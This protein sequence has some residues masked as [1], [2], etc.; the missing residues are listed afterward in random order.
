LA[1]VR[2]RPLCVQH[3]S[4]TPLFPASGPA[5]RSS[6]AFHPKS[7]FLTPPSRPWPG[8]DRDVT[9]LRADRSLLM[10]SAHSAARGSGA[11]ALQWCF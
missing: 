8:K 10:L 1:G 3:F 4:F 7:N 9:S 2:Y 11:P 5:T 6:N